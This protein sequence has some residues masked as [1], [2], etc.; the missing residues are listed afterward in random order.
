MVIFE[1]ARDPLRWPSE[2]YFRKRELRASNGHL[3]WSRAGGLQSGMSGL[4]NI[5]PPSSQSLAVKEFWF[6][7]CGIWGPDVWRNLREISCGHFPWKNKGENLWKNSSKF[8][9]IFRQ[10]FQIDRPKISPEFRS[11]ELQ[12][13]QIYQQP[14]YIT[15]CE[16]RCLIQT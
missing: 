14:E 16:L 8:R 13:Q 1:P 15:W 2:P 10:S 6:T 11:G 9:R 12:A 4:S 3:N 5:G 7:A